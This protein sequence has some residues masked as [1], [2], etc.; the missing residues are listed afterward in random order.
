V[1]HLLALYAMLATAGAV[2]GIV[3][4][5][6]VVCRAMKEPE[7]AGKFESVRAE[8][9]RFRKRPAQPAGTLGPTMAQSAHSDTATPDPPGVSK[10]A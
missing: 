10:V 9:L 8:L 3:I 5:H 4:L 1:K 7:V 2:L 6:T